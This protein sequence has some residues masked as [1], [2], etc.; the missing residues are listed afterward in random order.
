[1]RD[2]ILVVNKP[3]GMTSHDVILKVRKILQT[4]KVGHT[5]TLDPD[6]TGVLPLCIG[7]ATKLVEY[8]QE[9]PKTYI[10][11]WRA[12]YST[13]TEDATG[14]IVEQIENVRLQA[15][16]VIRTFQSFVGSY[17]QQP[18]MY[19]AVKIGG[20]KLYELAREGKIIERPSR[21]VM[22]Y[23]IELVEM[24]LDLKYPVVTFRVRCSKGT[25]IRTLCVDIG[26]ALGVPAHMLSL[27]RIES[28]GFTMSDSLTLEEIEQAVNRGDLDR[29]IIPLE[30]ALCDLPQFTVPEYLVEKIR[31]GQPILKRLPLPTGLPS[32]ELVRIF[33]PDGKL[34]ALHKVID[35]DETWSVP[36]K[37]LFL[38]E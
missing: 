7:R 22:I 21:T 17:T 24:N 27:Q 38:R 10:A 34:L 15:E 11:I 32:G 9:R 12:G 26:R 19:S 30:K 14:N 36:E 35:R 33:S 2:G 31:N 20:K 3:A 1:M 8:L 29:I 37:I 16:Q 18:P 28:A 5:G 25:Y 6:V 23:E 13:D 4:K